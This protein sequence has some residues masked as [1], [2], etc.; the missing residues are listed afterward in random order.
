[1][2]I[3]MVRK[4]CHVTGGKG[5]MAIVRVIKDVTLLRKNVGTWL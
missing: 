5:D 2:S 4:E 1:M 3:V